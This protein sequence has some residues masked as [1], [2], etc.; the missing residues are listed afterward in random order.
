M[1]TEASRIQ[2]APREERYPSDL[3]DAE[4]VIVEPMIPP[5]RRGGRPRETSMRE[6]MNAVRYVLRTG[7]QWRQLPKDFPPR[8]TVYNYFWA[9]TRY[10]VLDRMHHA[11]LVKL[12]EAEGREASPSAAILDTQAVKATEKG[13]RTRDPVGYDAGK[14]T[15]GIKRNALVDTIGLLLGIEVIPASVQDRDC[16]AGL[17]RTTR[18]LFPWI[19]KVFADGGYAGPKLK[20]AMA[21]QPVDLEI[22]KRTDKEGGFKVVRRRWVVERTFSWLRRNRRLMAHYE[23]V[24]IVAEG[25]AKLAMIAVMLKR[26]TKTTPFT[27]S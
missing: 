19:A 20:A 15:K 3:T 18:R 5:P 1:W 16:A 25:F 13:G 10:G 4:W 8:S 14:K 7:C 2:H 27:A 21:N 24:A 11:L 6:V 23:A 9:W 17:I 26:L 12:R 22:V